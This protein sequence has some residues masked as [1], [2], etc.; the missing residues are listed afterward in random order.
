[1]M[2]NLQ[3]C[4]S[5]RSKNELIGADYTQFDSKLIIKLNMAKSYALLALHLNLV[6]YRLK[7]Y[8]LR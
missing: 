5:L 4:L 1:M 3:S 8:L 2:N 6:I 7:I